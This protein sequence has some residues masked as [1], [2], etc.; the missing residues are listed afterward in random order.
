[1]TIA[2]RLRTPTLIVRARATT[3]TLP[4]YDEAA[5]KAATGGSW[6][7]LDSTGT[8]IYSGS[9]SVVANIAQFSVTIASTHVY[10][11][12]YRLSAEITYTGGTVYV[13]HEVYVV[14]YAP[15]PALRYLDL[16]AIEPRLDPALGQAGWAT[17]TGYDDQLD[18]AWV[19]ITN[20]LIS[21]GNRPHLIVGSSALNG[22]HAYLTLHLIFQGMSH[23]DNADFAAKADHYWSRYDSEWSTLTFREDVSG[24][25]ASATL[26]RR[27][28][29]RVVFLTSRG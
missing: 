22:L 16:Y 7:I 18:T 17:T 13:E 2:P 12:D 11:E 3:I 8:A 4:I 10:G 5:L 27:A 15:T 23:I 28:T 25:T 24:D 9:L 19:M 20:R 6:S 29:S 1:M 21:K 26:G 14:R